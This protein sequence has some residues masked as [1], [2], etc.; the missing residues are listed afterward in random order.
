MDVV[1]IRL[2]APAAPSAAYPVLVVED[3]RVVPLV[4]HTVT[5]GRSSRNDIKIVR[6]PVS[7]VHATIVRT[8][9]GYK[10]VDSGSKNGVTVN[11][12]P[13]KEHYLQDG[14]RIGLANVCLRFS[15]PNADETAATQETRPVAARAGSPWRI[16]DRTVRG[17]GRLI[18]GAV[19]LA[20]CAALVGS[21]A[22]RPARDGTDE[23]KTSLEAI[24]QSSETQRAMVETLTEQVC[25]LRRQIEQLR[26]QASGPSPSE[27]LRLRFEKK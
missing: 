21:L 8:P 25:E 12:E 23:V 18:A 14:D 20:A 3:G 13:V 27:E 26:A 1:N 4:K 9:I 17:R 24:R 15:N 5:I 19:L 11:D 7:R 2:N 16:V 10:I 22:F 6:G